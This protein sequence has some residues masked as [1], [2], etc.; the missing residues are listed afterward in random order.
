MKTTKYQL[1]YRSPDH[2]KGPDFWQKTGQIFKTQEKAEAVAAKAR[3]KF[4]GDEWKVQ[5]R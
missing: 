5:E 2:S 4:P 3:A 1:I